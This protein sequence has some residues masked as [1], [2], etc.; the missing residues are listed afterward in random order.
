[1]QHHAP[2]PFAA[3][4][5]AEGAGREAVSA[6]MRRVHVRVQPGVGHGFMNEERADRF[7]AA[8]AAQGWDAALAYLRA[9]L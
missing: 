1:M 2:T 6:G 5:A 7:D 9:E 4:I 8:A 3:T